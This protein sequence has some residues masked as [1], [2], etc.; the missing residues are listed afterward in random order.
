MARFRP[1]AEGGRQVQEATAITQV[2]SADLVA[3]PAA[4]GMA[5][6]MVAGGTDGTGTEPAEDE[7]GDVPATKDDIL[8]AFAEASEEELAELGLARAAETTTEE[9]ETEP[10]K[11]AERQTEAAGVREGQLHGR[12]MVKAKVEDAGLPVAVIEGVRE[13]LPD[14]ITEADV[15]A[16]IA[17]LKDSMGVMERAQLMP[18][19]ASTKVT[20]ES[21]DKKIA[22]LDKFFEGKFSE[23]YR[24][25]KQAWQD[26][27]GHRTQA[28]DADVNKLML[29]E[30][31]GLYDSGDRMRVE[32]GTA[33][34]REG[35]DSTSWN[36]VLGDSITRRMIAEYSRPDLGLWRQVVSS[37][38]PLNDFRTQRI[39]RIGGYGTL[40]ASTRAPR[41]SR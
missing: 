30:S 23:G 40:P 8:A 1:V 10:E 34:V 33:R 17:A 13:S 19:V 3:D 28:W 35:M 31:V 5:T 7:E 15:D 26:F 39:E 20:Q 14:R 32:E 4:G 27:T 38:V 18:T 29:R 11:P 16:R 12:L 6:R 41:T 24:S 9:T 25:F 22:A 37:I 2:N 36:L 21:L